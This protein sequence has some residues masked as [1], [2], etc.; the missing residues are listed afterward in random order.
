MKVYVADAHA[1]VQSL[2]SLVKTVTVPGE[3]TTEEQSSVVSF[4][5]VKGRSA[6]DIHK[7]IFPVC[8]GKC[9][10]R[11]AV[12]SSKHTRVNGLGRL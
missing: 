11:K 12:H 7:E 2:V 10:S 5:W 4:L 8:G 3:C 1:H 9:W 6:N